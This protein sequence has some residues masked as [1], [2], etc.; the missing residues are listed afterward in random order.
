MFTLAYKIKLANALTLSTYCVQNLSTTSSIKSQGKAVLYFFRF[1]FM[2]E[3]SHE[4]E[5]NNK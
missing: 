5:G 1:K 3:D 4:E 2:K